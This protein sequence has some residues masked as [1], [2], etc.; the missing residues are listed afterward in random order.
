LG[1]EGQNRWRKRIK[2]EFSLFVRTPHLNHLGV[3]KKTD[4]L[5]EVLPIL[6]LPGLGARNIATDSVRLELLGHFPVAPVNQS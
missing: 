3:V 4:P 5:A 2:Q 6:S 1:T